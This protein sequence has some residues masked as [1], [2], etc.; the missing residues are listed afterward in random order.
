EDGTL[1]V[2]LDP[3]LAGSHGAVGAAMQNDIDDRIECACRQ[4][5]GARDEI[6]CR[7]VDEPI[8]GPVAPDLLEHRLD[9]I[10]LTDVADHIRGLAATL[11]PL[12]DCPFPHLLTPAADHDLRAKLDEAGPQALADARSPSGDEALLSFE[13]MARE[14]LQMSPCWVTY[15]DVTIYG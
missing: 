13:Y 7:I 4:R 5:L 3:P 1:V 8:E 15:A 9:L 11:R 2:P 6:T 12:R 10:G 14:H